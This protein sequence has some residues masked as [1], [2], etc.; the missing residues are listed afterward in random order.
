MRVADDA[1]EVVFDDVR[2]DVDDIEGRA[3]LTVDDPS[4]EGKSVGKSVD[5]ARVDD[6]SADEAT[7]VDSITKDP[8]SEDEVKLWV[9]DST[10]ETDNVSKATVGGVPHLPL[11]QEGIK[12]C[13]QRPTLTP[14]SV[15]TV[16]PTSKHDDAGPKPK[17]PSVV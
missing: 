10:I 5:N 2:D 15:E 17:A 1:A 6:S 12:R 16:S 7:K 13:I 9:E 3:E 14:V 4:I 8:S 11:G